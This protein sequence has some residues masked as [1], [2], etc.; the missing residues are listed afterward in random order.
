MKNVPKI[1][2]FLKRKKLISFHEFSLCFTSTKN[3][4]LA[5]F[6]REMNMETV[7]RVEVY[8]YSDFLAVIGGLM[9]IFFNNQS[10]IIEHSFLMFFFCLSG[11]FLGMSALSAIEFTYYGTLRWYWSAKREREQNMFVPVEE[12]KV[13]SVIP[14]DYQHPY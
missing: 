13:V 10:I 6:F 2:L 4:R 12:Q 1:I 7:K 14:V 11:L 5:V 9:G 3:A 8:T